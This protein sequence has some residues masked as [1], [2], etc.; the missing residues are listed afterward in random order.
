MSGKEWKWNASCLH[1]KNEQLKKLILYIYILTIT[2]ESVSYLPQ[3]YVDLDTLRNLL[4]EVTVFNDIIY[5]HQLA[6][7]T[8]PRAVSKSAPSCQE[9]WPYWQSVAVS[10]RGT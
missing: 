2:Y 4:T 5:L 6:V 9:I 8:P 3:S 1:A 7:S 10:D